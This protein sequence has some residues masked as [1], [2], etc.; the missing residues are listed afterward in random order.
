MKIDLSIGNDYN[1][2]LLKYVLFDNNFGDN[3]TKRIL[4]L[5]I[6]T[7]IE[8]RFASLTLGR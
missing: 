4:F 1:S 7:S 2:D 3:L 6:I 8:L 5:R